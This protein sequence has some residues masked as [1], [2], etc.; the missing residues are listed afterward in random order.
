VSTEKS[1]PRSVLD[2]KKVPSKDFKTIA[3]SSIGAHATDNLIQLTF[4]LEI[5]DPDNEQ[6]TVIMEEIR[7]VVTPRTLKLIQVVCAGLIEGLEG[8]I[9]EI[10]VSAPAITTTFEKRT[11]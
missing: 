8:V 4:G 1:E 7:V 11:K 2:K 9:G 10:P 3:V 6:E 5:P